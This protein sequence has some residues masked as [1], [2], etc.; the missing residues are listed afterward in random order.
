MYGIM[1]PII[2]PRRDQDG[3]GDLDNSGSNSF[4]NSSLKKKKFVG[5]VEGEQY[6]DQQFVNTHTAR[7][8]S[9]E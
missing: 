7:Q 6:F 8:N 3:E 5:T 2:K 4:L 1:K 9:L